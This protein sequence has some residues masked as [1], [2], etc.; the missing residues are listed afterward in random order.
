MRYAVLG[1]GKRLRPIIALATT[2]AFEVPIDRALAPAC[3]VE[4]I[5]AY[6][7]V[8][9]DLPALD[10]DDLRRGHPTCHKA[11]GEA[12]AIL[13]GDALQSCAFQ[14]LSEA[15]ELCLEVR[16]EMTR[17]LSHAVGHAGMVGGQALDLELEAQAVGVEELQT[18]HRMKTGALLETSVILGG[19]AGGADSEHLEVLAPYGAHIGLAFQITDD[20]LDVEGNTEAL[21]KTVGADA[22]HHKV[23]YPA[24]LGIDEAKR[25]AARELDAALAWLQGWGP[26]AW[27]LR[28]LAR[29]VVK[30]ES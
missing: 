14:T 18:I 22:S 16:L 2:E 15:E 9:D 3:A 24:L 28:E 4:F 6:S 7:L 10:N 1:N 23:T 11:F 5:H 29:Y 27:P 17:R 26:A 25:L 13:V 8:H 20:I 30:R 12:T 21:G 19:L